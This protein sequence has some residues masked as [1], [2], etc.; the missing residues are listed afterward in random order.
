M[1][2]T[3]IQKYMASL[4]DFASGAA[5]TDFSGNS[6]PL[7]QAVDRVID[8]VRA[9]VAAGGKI[10]FI[11]NGGSAGIASHLAIDYTKNG[12]LRATAFNDPAALTCLGNDFGFEHVFAKQI[13]AHARPDDLLV[14]ISSSGRSADILNGVAAARGRKCAVVTMSGFK[15]DNPLRKLGDYNFFVGSGE[16]GFVEIAHLALCHAVLD[17]A[18]GWRAAGDLSAAVARA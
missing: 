16:Y 11:G 14:A 8:K 4:H 15:G 7:Q 9:G 10:M 18:M 1:T 2:E 13:E 5:A 3:P 17:L 6:L 12:G